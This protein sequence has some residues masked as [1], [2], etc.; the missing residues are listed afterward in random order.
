MFKP[1]MNIWKKVSCF[2]SLDFTHDR[3]IIDGFDILKTA[4]NEEFIKD[5]QDEENIFECGDQM[6]WSG[7][8]NHAE[9][10]YND[11]VDKER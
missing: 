6:N 7:I 9:D 5:I 11:V 1:Y 10:V 8:M 4:T 2:T 3:L